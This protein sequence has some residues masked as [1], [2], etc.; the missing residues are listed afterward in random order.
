MLFEL[1]IKW[2]VCNTL[3]AK[4]AFIFYDLAVCII[5]FING[6]VL[7]ILTSSFDGD[8]LS[9]VGPVINVTD[10]VR[11]IRITGT[12]TRRNIPLPFRGGGGAK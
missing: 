10:H 1:R 5:I 7:C 6:W 3:R 2:F 12:R 9:I 8:R 4:N 11:D